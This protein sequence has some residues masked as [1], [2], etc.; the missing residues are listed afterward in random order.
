M[1]SPERRRLGEVV[2]G[3]GT[4]AAACAQSKAGGRRGRPRTRRPLPSPV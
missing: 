1:T 2:S 3:R 4:H